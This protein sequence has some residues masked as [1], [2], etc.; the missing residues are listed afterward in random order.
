MERAIK[1]FAWLNDVLL[2]RFGLYVTNS[3]RNLRNVVSRQLKSNSIEVVFDVGAS[4][5]Q[6][7]AGLRKG[8]FRGLIYSFEPLKKPFQELES[9]AKA[10]GMWSAHNIGL[11]SSNEI[12]EINVAENSV[13]SSLLEMTSLHTINAPKSKVV[14]SELIEIQKLDH[15]LDSINLVNQQKIHLKIDVQ[16][17]TK[18]VLL[19]AKKFLRNPDLLSIE[20]ELD[21]AKVY[22]GQPNWLEIVTTLEKFDFKLFS[23]SGGFY[24]VENG[25]IL[26]LDAFFAKEIKYLNA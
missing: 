9:L 18:E 24:D 13:S 16:G 21:L 4:Y 22:V 19:G 15:F 7:G 23:C 12:R 2:C 20:V 17:F 11:G 8:G 5:G 14:N 26:Q 1:F 6:Y 10:D 25:Q 3:N